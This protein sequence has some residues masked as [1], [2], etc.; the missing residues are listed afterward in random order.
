M[1][2][3]SR[4]VTCSNCNHGYSSNVFTYCPSCGASGT[5]ADMHDW[6]EPQIIQSLS[7]ETPSDG[8][9]EEEGSAFDTQVGGGHYKDM[10]IQPAYYCQK[11]RLNHCESAIVKYASRHQDKNGAEDIKKIIHYA[12]MILEMEYGD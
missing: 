1:T 6:V 7:L 3:L 9:C 11:N 2:L 8:P 4:E 12:R 10:E 5:I